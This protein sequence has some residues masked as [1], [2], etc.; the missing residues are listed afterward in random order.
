V[1]T[2]FDCPSLIKMLIVARLHGR[3]RRRVRAQIPGFRGVALIKHWSERRLYSVSLWDERSAVL[4]MG[5]VRQH[6]LAARLTRRLGIATSGG[7]FA[8]AGDWREVILDDDV[9]DGWVGPSPLS[10]K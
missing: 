3:I 2:R 4:Q 8:Y 7:V 10:R 9:R 1:I 6:V 5:E